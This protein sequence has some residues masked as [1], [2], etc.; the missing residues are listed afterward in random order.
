M[1]KL[2]NKSKSNSQIA[3]SLRFADT[4]FLKLKGLMFDRSMQTGSALFFEGTRCIHTCFMNF[5]IDT[6]FVDK[7]MIVERTFENMKPW[8][9][10]PI[11]WRASSVIELPPGT[12]KSNKVDIGDELYVGD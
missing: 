3:D 12:L 4:Y 10:S 2:L 1:K 11:V 5:S 9:L 7:N 6:I 8:R